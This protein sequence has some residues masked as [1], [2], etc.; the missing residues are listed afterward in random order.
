MQSL[1]RYQVTLTDGGYSVGIS[2]RGLSL[3][4]CHNGNVLRCNGALRYAALVR[5][6][7]TNWD[8]LVRGHYDQ[9]FWNLV[10][11]VVGNAA[12]MCM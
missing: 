11:E 3:A 10:R 8:T 6:I 5:Y 4:V 7:E 9:R 12:V 1:L 2:N